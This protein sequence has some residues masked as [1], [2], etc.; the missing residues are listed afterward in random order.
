MRNTEEEKMILLRHNIRNIRKQ[1]AYMDAADF[2]TLQYIHA[3]W[4]QVH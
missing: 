2:I 3:R 4:A 1:N